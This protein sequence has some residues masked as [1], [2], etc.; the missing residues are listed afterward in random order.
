MPA[1]AYS[2][3]SVQQMLAGRRLTSLKGGNRGR[4]SPGY[5]DLSC[6]FLVSVAKL[7][8]TVMFMSF[9]GSV[10]IHRCRFCG[11]CWR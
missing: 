6:A 5:G 4:E 2:L 1:P 11:T 9:V 10:I 8:V 7:L 3:V